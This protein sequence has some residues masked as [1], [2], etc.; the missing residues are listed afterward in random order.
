MEQKKFEIRTKITMNSFMNYF[1]VNESFV[2]RSINKL[3]KILTICARFVII[4]K[5]RATTVHT[6][7][8]SKTRY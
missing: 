8:N 4:H 2:T 7:P 5:F 3:K 1:N 6:Y